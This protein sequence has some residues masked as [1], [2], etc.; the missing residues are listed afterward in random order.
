MQILV[1]ATEYFDAAFKSLFKVKLKYMDKSWMSI[2]QCFTESIL[3]KNKWI[4]LNLQATLKNFWVLQKLMELLLSLRNSKQNTVSLVWQK[5]T[6]V[7]LLSVRVRL[8]P[9]NQDSGTLTG[10]HKE[11]GQVSETQGH[12]MNW[13]GGETTVYLSICLST[14]MLSCHWCY[15]YCT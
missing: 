15:Y 12:M 7:S 13:E 6:I 14:E 10:T 9:P 2:N 1:W 11:I 8:W 5:E 3:A 4:K